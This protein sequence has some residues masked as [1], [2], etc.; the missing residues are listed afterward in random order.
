MNVTY[1]NGSSSTRS[2]VGFRS[3]LGIDDL[4]LSED[5]MEI[6]TRQSDVGTLTSDSTPL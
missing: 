6:G 1:R 2:Q 5:V 4:E 3:I